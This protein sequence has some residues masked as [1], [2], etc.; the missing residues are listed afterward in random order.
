[1]DKKASRYQ[2]VYA[3]LSEL[4]KSTTDIYARMATI[5]AILYH[6]MNGFFWVGF[7]LLKEG[8]L[9]VGPYQ[10]PVACQVLAKNAGVC[11]AAINEVKEQIVPDV[12]K[13]PGH[14]ACDSRSK[15]EIAL[16]L[17]DDH[18]N[19]CGVLDVDSK[20]ENN[21]DQTDAE[22]LTKIIQLIHN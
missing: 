20:E 15:S 22:Y 9:T 14:I 7:Y 3:Q 6:K 16:P 5:N 19:I 11:W 12:T 18:Q 17:Y 1:M 21:F 2:R 13:F 4:L 8:E 10:G